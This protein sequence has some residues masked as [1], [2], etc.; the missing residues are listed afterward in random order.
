MRGV[1]L[2]SAP[3]VSEHG[4]SCEAR[5]YTLTCRWS[6]FETTNPFAVYKP[7]PYSGDANRSGR[8]HAQFIDHRLGSGGARARDL[9]DGLRDF[10]L[11]D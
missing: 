1:G 6:A 4:V 10:S 9:S 5:S 8:N 3:G 11:V 2:G 7:R